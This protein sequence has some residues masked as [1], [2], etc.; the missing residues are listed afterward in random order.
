M[1]METRNFRNRRIRLA[2]RTSVAS[3]L[4]SFALQVAAIPVALSALGA[5]RFGLY[6][7]LVSLL[8]WIDLGTVGIGPGLTRGISLAWGNG[9]RDGERKYFASASA[10]LSVIAALFLFATAIFYFMYVWGREGAAIELL[11][12]KGAIAFKNELMQAAAV[13]GAFFVLQLFFSIGERARSAYQEDYVTNALSL[14]SNLISLAAM[15]AIARYWPTIPG[16][17]VAVFGALA[18]SK[19]VNTILL[20]IVRPYLIPTL[21]HVN[22]VAVKELMTDGLPFWVVQ[23]ASLTLHNLTLV[24]VG[25]IA[26]PT[27][28]AQFAVI[29]RFTQLAATGV[30]MYTQPL[31]PAITHATITNDRAWIIKSYKKY[32]KITLIYSSVVALSLTLLGP[33]VLRIWANS[34]IVFDRQLV[35]VLGVYFV[36]WM[37]NHF[38]TIVFFGFGWLREIALFM[39]IEAILAVAL[40]SAL[41]QRFGSIGMAVGLCLA[42]LAINIWALP[43]IIW[44]RAIKSPATG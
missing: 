7:I 33:T 27:N 32:A 25:S 10:L 11:I 4:A 13:I 30:M 29:F 5:E 26:G 14:M 24:L 1:T 12:N 23:V 9:D 6:T 2:V 20:L 8:V 36:I 17:A 37:F 19:L 44:R 38:N 39:T 28:L 41:T 43:Y 34:E 22:R 40:G 18:I 31:W 35:T 21:A 3:K 15:F 42:G 16:F